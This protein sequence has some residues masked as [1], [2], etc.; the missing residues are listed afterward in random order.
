[1]KWTTTTVLLAL[2]GTASAGGLARPNGLSARGVGMGGAFVAIADD[3]T[4]VFFNPA[5]LDAQPAQ[6]MLGGELVYGPRTYTPVAADGTRGPEQSTSVTAPV[7][8]IGF[9]GRLGD[10]NRPSRLTFGLGVFNTFGGQVAYEKTGMPALDST[11]DIVIELD[12]AVALH[13]SDRLSLGAGVRMGFGLFHV[14]S[15]MMPF[16]ANLSASGI[17]RACRSAHSSGRQTG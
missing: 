15:T 3:P 9:V 2:T 4:A 8:S 12:G 1:M 5:A 17:G 16:D 7:P 11:R 14:E 13:V 6:I 10:S